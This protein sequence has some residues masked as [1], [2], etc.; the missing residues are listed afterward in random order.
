MTSF[1]K[2]RRKRALKCQLSPRDVIWELRQVKKEFLEVYTLQKIKKPEHFSH[3]FQY[4]QT[5]KNV[6][7]CLGLCLAASSAPLFRKSAWI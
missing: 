5:Y 1:Q 2:L 7:C 3:R 4:W 6:L